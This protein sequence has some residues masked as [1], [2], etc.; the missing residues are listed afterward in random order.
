MELFWTQ[1]SISNFYTYLS[2]FGEAWNAATDHVATLTPGVN[3][4]FP[5]Q[6]PI[7]SETSFFNNFGAALSVLGGGIGLFGGE[8]PGAAVAGGVVG[9]IGGVFSDVGAN[10]QA[11]TPPDGLR[12]LDSR[13][14]SVYSQVS[15]NTGLL[16]T[17]VMKNGNLSAYPNRL[18][19]GSQYNNTLVAF[20]DN[21]NFFYFPDNYTVQALQPLLS[22]QLLVNIVGAAILE[23]NYYILKDAYAVAD[24]PAGTNLTGLVIDNSCFTLEVAGQGGQ[25]TGQAAVSTRSSFSNQ[26][27]PITA[28]KLGDS[29]QLSLSDLYTSSYSC[30][31]ANNAYGSTVDLSNLDLNITAIP[32]CFYN[33]PVFQVTPPTE[34]TGDTAG[35]PCAIFEA[36]STAKTPAVGLTF[37]PDNLSPI[38]TQEFC[39]NLQSTSHLRFGLID[40]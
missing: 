14:S 37:L 34:K 4:D 15:N 30:Q 17:A 16:L 39:K 9:M 13:L 1:N 21:G 40:S 3:D 7:V 28:G 11:G 22:H 24:C 26:M 31:N 19:S 36:N 27:D 8:N 6:V 2:I 33:L 12:D 25:N 5:I 20:F 23:A 35:S 32:P 10:L 29:Y 38:F 18:F